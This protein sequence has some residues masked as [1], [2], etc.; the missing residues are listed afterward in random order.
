MAER[1]RRYGIL[2]KAKTGR[3]AAPL[4]WVKTVEEEIKAGTA[5]PTTL[6]RRQE[7]E[8]EQMVIESLQVARAA[9]FH[10]QEVVSTRERRLSRSGKGLVAPLALPAHRNAAPS[11]ATSSSTA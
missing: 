8:F 3:L 2:D 9:L 6:D 1:N 10:F 7:H 4:K 11:S 5:A